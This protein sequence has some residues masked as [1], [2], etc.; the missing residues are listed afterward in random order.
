MSLSSALKELNVNWFTRLRPR[1]V[2]IIG[3]YAGK[4]TFLVDGDA[5]IQYVLDDHL[6]GIG[7]QHSEYPSRTVYFF[8]FFFFFSFWSISVSYG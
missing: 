7:K 1:W 2:D 6:L 3:A 4:E 8:F 5:L